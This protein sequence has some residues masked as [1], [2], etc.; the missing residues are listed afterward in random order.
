MLPSFDYQIPLLGLPRILGLDLSNI[1]GDVPYLVPPTDR[2]ERWKKRL[3]SVSELK[4]GLVWAGSA[5]QGTESR[6]RSV[7]V[8]KPLLTVGGVI[9]FNLQVGPDSSQKPGDGVELIDYTADL[10]DFAETA[11]LIQNLDLV[12]SVDTSVAH[13]AGALAKPV[14]VLI[15]AQN[16]FRWLL[17]RT[18]TPWY[19]TMRLFRQRVGGDWQAPIAEMVD[20][21]RAFERERT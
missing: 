13:L 17:D 9:F 18:D 16:D 14:W 6:S 4:V 10:T 5:Y 15:P 19:P 20:A 3:K 2:A 11:A 8:Y 1:P 21:L 12:I 7:D